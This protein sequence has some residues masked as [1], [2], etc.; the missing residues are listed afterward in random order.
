MPPTRTQ[1]GSTISG[2]TSGSPASVGGINTAL[3]AC[4]PGTYVLLGSG[5]WLTN[6]TSINMNSFSGVSLRG[7]GAMA[8]I[9][10][11][12]SGDQF[13][14][15]NSNQAGYGALSAVYAAGTTSIT[16]TG[17]SSTPAVGM[18]VILNQCDTGVTGCGYVNTNGGTAVTLFTSLNATPFQSGWAGDTININGVN[19]TIASVTDSTDLVTTSGVPA[20]GGTGYSIGSPTDNNSL[21]ICGDYPV[22][23][24]ETE[25]VGNPPY[26]HQYQFVVITSVTNNGG[27]SYTLGITPGLYM[28]NWGSVATTGASLSWLTPT[29]G[30]GIEDMTVMNPASSNY[31][32]ANGGNV[33][34]NQLYGSWIKGVRFI[35][36]G[37]NNAVGWNTSV[38]SLFSNNY[39]VA[40]ISFVANKG[41]NSIHDGL[42]VGQSSDVLVLNNISAIGMVQEYRGGDSGVV[43]IYNF[44]RDAFT[45]YAFNL[46]SYDH[47]GGGALN[48]YEG[49]EAGAMDEDSTWGTHDLNTYFRNNIACFDAPYAGGGGSP[50]PPNSRGLQIDGGQRF[51]NAI[52]N[53]IG[54]VSECPTYQ[55]ASTGSAFQI[56]TNDALTAT[57]LMRWGNVTVDA[58]SSDT[59]SNSGVR[60]VSSEVPSSLSSPNTAWQNPVPSNNNLPCSFYFSVGTSP[61]TPLNGGTGLSWWKVCKTWSTF[62]T[63]CA[64]TQTPPFPP[65]GPEL[66]GGPYVNGYGYDNPAAVAWTNLPIDTTFQNSYTI[67]SSS[68][69]NVSSTCSPAPAP[70]E[71]LTFAGGVLPNLTHVLGSFQLSGVNSA[72]SIGASFN[73]TTNAEILMTN[74]TATTVVYSLAS[75]PGVSCTGTMK[76]PDVRQFDERVYESDPGNSQAGPTPPATVNATVQP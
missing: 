55:G 74:S 56:Y 72:C 28:P 69:S 21:Y 67:S 40:D 17:A 47:A 36:T 70:C 65:N 1:C 64:T 52:G 63:S 50:Y 10:E 32:N 19:Y 30:I 54:T 18:V 39:D 68:W 24:C 31:T 59:P 29:T 11:V 16:V 33:Q 45:A 75:N 9:F 38:R 4:K 58:Q 23:Y 66:T 60:F 43:T 12:S 13:N 53:V 61:C 37:N 20:A 71:T 46:W 7:S 48:L 25:N 34:T 27:G 76:F 35:G 26:N 5:Y 57:T 2:G 42:I 22:G 51:E 3:A 73:P 44:G 6:G 14:M 8:T 15:G 41:Y 49:N 62:P